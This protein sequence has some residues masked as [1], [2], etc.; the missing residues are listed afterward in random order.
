MRTSTRLLS[1]FALATSA[2]LITAPTA[3]RAAAGSEQ[4]VG[5]LINTTASARFTRPFTL[6]IDRYGSQADAQRL[7]GVLAARGQLA[8]RDELWRRNAGYLSIG[9]GLGYPIAAAF[10]E[11]TPSGR[12]IRVFLDRPLGFLETQYFRRS[13]SYPFTVIELSLDKNGNGE[14]LF[15]AAAKLQWHGDTLEVESLGVMPNRLLHVRAS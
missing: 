7:T 11:E 1:I 8:L 15:I 13:Y 9:G 5:H 3:A 14:G 4:F 2:L 10:S 6:E 12:T